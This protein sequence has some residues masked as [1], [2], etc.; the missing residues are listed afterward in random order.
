MRA[1]PLS[2]LAQPSGCRAGTVRWPTALPRALRV[3]PWDLRDA[4]ENR[5][6]VAARPEIDWRPWIDG[7]GR[8]GP[9]RLFGARIAVSRSGLEA[10]LS[11]GG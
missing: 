7:P 3:A 6:F 4:P 8:G 5:A 9:Y 2:L 11:R 1:L 10:S